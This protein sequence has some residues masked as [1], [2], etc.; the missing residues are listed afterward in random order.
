MVELKINPSE[1]NKSQILRLC[2]YL[3]EKKIN[4]TGEGVFMNSNPE[5]LSDEDSWKMEDIIRKS[6]RY[7]K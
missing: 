5:E 4:F 3:I 7:Y 2:V 1:L 6:K